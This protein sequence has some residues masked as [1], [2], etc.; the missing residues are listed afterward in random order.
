MSR[1]VIAKIFMI[2]ILV[3]GVRMGMLTSKSKN[4]GRLLVGILLY[5][6]IYYSIFGWWL[7]AI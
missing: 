7:K 6:V 5:V 1:E 4:A 2:P 3:G